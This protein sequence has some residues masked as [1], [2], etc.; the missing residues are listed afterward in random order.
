MTMTVRDICGNADLFRAAYP[1]WPHAEPAP[2]TVAWREITARFP[3]LAGTPTRRGMAPDTRCL[4]ADVQPGTAFSGGGFELIRAVAAAFDVEAGELTVTG[5][6]PH[7]SGTE[8]TVFCKVPIGDALVIVQA[9]ACTCHLSPAP[10][11]PDAERCTSCG[12]ETGC[13]CSCCDSDKCPACDEV[14]ADVQP[15][16]ACPDH[17]HAYVYDRSEDYE[18]HDKCPEPGCTQGRWT[19]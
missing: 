16:W 9:S 2:V 18:D 5:V 11:V 17:G 7:A 15:G 19:G 8:H 4:Y 3:E 1:N 14:H 12:H 10:A 13:E 6:P